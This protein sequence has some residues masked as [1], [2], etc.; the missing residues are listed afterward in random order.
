[1]AG[2][3][4]NAADRLAAIR[5]AFPAQGFFRDKEW[6]LSPESFPLEPE[7]LKTIECLGPALLAF[8]RA[9]NRLY[10]ESA[11][12]G[13]HAWVARLLDQGKPRHIID[14]GR[15][16]A[17]RDELPRVIRPDLVLTEDGVCLSEIDSLPG[18]IGLTAWLN[19]TYASLGDGVIGGERG[20]IEG[21]AA[22]FPDEDILISRE[23]G[24]YEPEMRYLAEALRDRQLT[25]TAAFVPPSESQPSRSCYRFF[26]LFDLENVEH[27]RE[28]LR[29]AGAGGIRF[30]PPLKAFLEEKLWLGLFWSPQLEP[31]WRENLSDEHFALLRRCIPVGW[32]L[33]PAPLPVTAVYPGL[34]INSW[35]ELRAF[36]RKQR[37]LVIKISGFSEKSWGSRGVVIGHDLSHPDWSRAIDGALSSFP[38]NPFLLQR[39]HAGR[40]V[41][42]PAWDD[43]KSTTALMKAR[44]RLCPYYFVVN[45]TARL[46]G[47]LATVCPADKK[48]LHGMKDA[49]LLP[50]VPR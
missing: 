7:I 14:L 18:G 8:Q 15:H 4:G 39:F 31:W 24:D 21:F 26:E 33:N 35:D 30:T 36:G 20:M 2:K 32:V 1:M 16:E 50:C 46:S 10:F 28:L 27:S 37:E 40:I 49:M 19:Q 48:L 47:V 38:Q 23:S 6:L 44:V 34:E 5:S 11:A 43:M 3:I 29:L 25:R 42:H 41:H 17:W 45:H 13:E 22:A 9:C 12:G